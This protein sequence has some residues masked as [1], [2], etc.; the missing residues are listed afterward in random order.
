[1]YNDIFR[2]VLK[3]KWSLWILEGMR[4][5]LTFRRP[6]PYKLVTIQDIIFKRLSMIRNWIF[7]SIQSIHS[8]LMVFVVQS[9][10]ER[11]NKK[12]AAIDCLRDLTELH[13]SYVNAMH[14][15]C[16]RRRTDADLRDGIDQLCQLSAVLNDEWKNLHSIQCFENAQS[17]AIDAS[18]IGEQIDNIETVYIKCHTFIAKRLSKEVYANNR[19][20][21]KWFLVIFVLFLFHRKY[22][23]KH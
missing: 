18:K 10:N 19:N 22:H 15:Y 8:H 17:D 4:F 14:R 13:D 1:M 9:M 12:L 16:F 11:F 6:V 7:Y 5:P 3:I 2:F 21:C 20:E 23:I